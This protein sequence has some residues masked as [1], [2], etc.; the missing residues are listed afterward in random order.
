MITITLN[1]IMIDIKGLKVLSIHRPCPLGAVQFIEC[2]LNSNLPPFKL[3]HQTL[4][5]LLE[6]FGAVSS[7]NPPICYVLYY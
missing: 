2:N 4:L 5:V 1:C 3:P 6:L 7:S